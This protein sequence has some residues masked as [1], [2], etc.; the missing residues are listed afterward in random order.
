MSHVCHST[1]SVLNLL[2]TCHTSLS[3]FWDII[4]CSF[5]CCIETIKYESATSRRQTRLN[6]LSCHNSTRPGVIRG[7]SFSRQLATLLG[8]IFKYN[9]MHI[10]INTRRRSKAVADAESRGTRRYVGYVKNG[11]P[12]PAEPVGRRLRC[13]QTHIEVTSLA[14]CHIRA[15]VLVWSE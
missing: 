9:I 2:N 4:R 1:Y 3:L 7:R 14:Q 12:E 5:C 15:I 10:R 11:R 6:V 13:T 8:P